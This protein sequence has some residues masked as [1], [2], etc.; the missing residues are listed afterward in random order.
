MFSASSVT[1]GQASTFNAEKAAPK[2]GAGLSQPA[3]AGNSA[4]IKKRS[5]GS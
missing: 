2:P 3:P 5:R 4:K 1:S